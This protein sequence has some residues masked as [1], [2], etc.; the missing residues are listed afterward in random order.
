MADFWE[1]VWK[2]GLFN[3]LYDNVNECG[4]ELHKHRE[5]VNKVKKKKKQFEHCVKF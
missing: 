5:K 1:N 4:T 2:K 3:Y